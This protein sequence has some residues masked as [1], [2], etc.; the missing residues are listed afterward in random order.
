VSYGATSTLS[1]SGGSGTGAITWSVGA[2]TGCTISNGTTL[3]NILASG[4][5][6]VTATKAADANYNAATSSPITVTLTPKNIT[7]TAIAATKVFGNTDPTFTYAPS[8]L[9]A[10]FTGL[11]GRVAGESV[12]VY[13]ITQGSLSAGVNYSITFV[14]ADLTITQATSS[15]IVSCPASETYTGSAIT[16]CSASY[17]TSDGLNGSSTVT[18]ANNVNVGTAIASSTYAG[19]ANH[20]ASSNAASFT[21]STA[22]SSVVVS[23]PAL[24]VYTGSTTSPCTASY[25]TSDGLSGSLVVAYSS[26]MNVGTASAS[27]TYAG[28]SNHVSSFSSATF[29][30][31]QATSSVTVSC[32]ASEIY[33]SSALAPCAASYLTSDG[34]SGSSTV[35]Y[36]SNINVGMA[37]ASSTYIGDANHQ[38][39]TNSANFSIVQATSSVTV[40]CPASE[41]YTGSAITPCSASY[42]TSDGLNGSSA[43]TYTNNVNVGTATASSTY[44]GDANHAASS[45]A[46]TFSIGNA[47]PA[48]TSLLPTSTPAGSADFTLT[49]DGSNFIVGSVV[50]WNGSARTTSFVSSTELTAT[51]VAADVSA[52]GTAALTVTNPAP[53]GGTSNAQTFTITATP[54]PVPVTTGIGPT[55]T[56]AGS[57]DFTLTVDGSNF[58]SDS[59]VQW[60]DS[61]RTTTFVSSSS[62]IATISASD[63]AFAGTVPITVMTP[64]PGGGISNTQTF[65]IE[66]PISTS[67]NAIRFIFANVTSSAVVGNGV[68]FNIEAVNSSGTVDASFQQGVTLTVGGSGTGG[69]LVTIID[70]I[71]TSTVS[72]N[73]AQTITLSLEDSQLT[74]LNVSSTAPVIFLPGPVLKFTLNHPG[75]M[76]TGTRL[77]YTIG[78]QDQFGNSVSL[79]S[80]TVAYLYSNSSSTN[81]AFFDAATGG[82][83]ISSTTILDGSTSTVFWYYDDTPGSRMIIVSDNAS[84]PDGA[85]GIVDASDTFMVAPGAVKFIFANVPSNVTA[86]SGVTANIYAVDSFDTIDP[87][88]NGGVTVTTSGSATGGG[89][90]TIVN[91]VGTTTITDATA[92]TVTLGLQDTQSTGLGVGA[93]TQT[94]F[95]AIPV[96][97][98]SISQTGGGSSPEAVVSGIK[99]GVTITFSGM[100]YPGAS[101]MVIRKDL[102]LQAMPVTQAVPA[103]ADGSFLAELDNVTRLTGQ[104][105]LLSFVDKNG[106]IAQTKAYN[107]PAQDKLVYGNILAAP[108]LGFQNGSISAK[109]KPIVIT[110]YATPAA[111]V[112]LFVDGNP[113]GTV[114]I[115]DPTGKYSYTINTDVLATGRHAIWAIQKYTQTA[116]E[117]SGYTN[118]LSQDEIF[119]DDATKG[120][121]LTTNASSGLY[122]FVPAVTDGA[123]GAVP[124]TVGKT[125]PKQAESDFSNQQ[126]FTISPLANPKLDLN[127]DGVVDVRDLSIFLAYLKNL[128]TS[129]TNFRI[130]DP[131]MVRTL[132]FNGDGV[133]DINDLNILSSAILHP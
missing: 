101:V 120:V 112:E 88:F 60:N 132:D 87:S 46:A 14:S 61:P 127:G 16:P 96:V 122:T 44:A 21:I 118:S 128:N 29:T 113:A 111:T 18:Y 97:T 90:I 69:G 121:L 125:Y 119:V 23:C 63:V 79:A 53:G 74:G 131:N 57:A 56:I 34:T 114:T 100:A 48:L 78:R 39:N 117:V 133:V 89:L 73:I 62:L 13:A 7:V 28:D 15:V 66:N 71:G 65:T 17:L 10:I 130:V 51:I 37:A 45:N 4:T 36:S 50:N 9:G 83:Q 99:P 107:V 103:A 102:G 26:N 58:I 98:P 25:L 110:G 85:A 55:S 68:V 129:L 126:S 32:P 2:S 95:N 31:T 64:T 75:N 35:V 92:E 109:G 33:T 115:H 43:V 1:S 40:T 5:C 104:T 12:G 76:N 81:A 22:T 93:T 116:L 47:L 24:V 77:G 30:I 106:L 11:L 3:T 86:G 94:V 70:G 41:S 20:A 8:D 123:G 6:Q 72:D 27:S 80:D 105:Y 54:N 82:T 38:G 19:D 108:T 91:G 67:T 124:V 49:V 59:V 52:T 84:A 42:L